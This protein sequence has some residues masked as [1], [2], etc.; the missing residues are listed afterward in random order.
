MAAVRAGGRCAGFIVFVVRI[1]DREVEF[2]LNDVVQGVFECAGK[3][4]AGEGNRQQLGL[5]ATCGH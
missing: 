2:F 4:L 5:F 3:D 1:D